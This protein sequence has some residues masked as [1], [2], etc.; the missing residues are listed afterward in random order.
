MVP[1]V[2]IPELAGLTEGLDLAL[3]DKLPIHINS[4]NKTK[5]VTL[6]QLNTFF[7]TGGGDTHPPVV[8]GGSMLYKVE[9][10]AAG[11]DTAS[12][13]SIAGQDFD[14]ERGGFP[15]EALLPDESNGP[16]GTNTAEYEILDSGGFKLLQSGDVLALGERFKLTLFNLIGG[17][18]GGGGSTVTSFIQ[19]K[20]VVSS[21]MTLDPLLDMNKLIQLRGE[22]TAITLTIPDISDIAANSFIPIESHINSNKPCSIVTTGG[23]YIYF[24]GG[25]KTTIY[26]HPGE[27]CWLYRDTDGL[28]II[29]D[30][31]ERYK[32]LAKP[33]AAFK[34]DLN[35]LVCKGQLVNRADYPRLW[36]Y[37]QT[38]GSS[39]VTDATW[40]TASVS[41]GGRTILKPYRGCFSSGDG[42]LTFRLPD[43]LGMTL[44]S[45]ISESGSDPL[46]HLNKPGGYQADYNKKFWFGTHAVLDVLKEDGTNTET[47]TDPGAGSPNIRT[48]VNIDQTIFND[49]ATV[50]NIGVLYVINV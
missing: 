4:E 31:A 26:M 44:T 34:A 48:G 27:V 43:L 32:Q 49:K 36:E 23:Q 2:R 17:G 7:A 38:L 15:L 11:T 40:N 16:L 1:T 14:L 29:N 25:S 19:G 42:S 45:V 18:G 9:A 21:N 20:K 10:P 28:Y 5:K 37:V 12:I 35:Q 47:G 33:T 6:Q 8:W 46:R 13:P 24:N 3:S 41:L 30:F 50:E 22:N 39:F